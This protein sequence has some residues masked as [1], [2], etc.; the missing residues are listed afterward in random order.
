VV[1][2]K[3]GL[4]T[5]Q[6]GLMSQIPK[7]LKIIVVVDAAFTLKGPK[8]ISSSPQIILLLEQEKVRHSWDGWS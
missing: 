5:Q 2:E 8:K 4:T 1:E 6:G 3:V 7:N